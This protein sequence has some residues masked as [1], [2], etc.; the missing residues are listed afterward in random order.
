MREFK[1]RQVV[2]RLIHSRAVL[3]LLIVVIVFLLKTVFGVYL[4]FKDS[5]AHRYAVQNELTEL[6]RRADSL[7]REVERL[8]TEKGIEEE[9]RR[10]F[11]MVKEGEGVAI[12]VDNQ[13][14]DEVQSV[15]EGRGFW[16]RVKGWFSVE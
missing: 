12:I 9:I 1:E 16:L 2:Y 11:S 4:K 3:F 14:E 10:Q 13:S 7:S 15:G 6:K 5:R 8:G